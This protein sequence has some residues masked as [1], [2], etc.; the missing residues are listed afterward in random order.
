MA[1]SCCDEDEYGDTRPSSVKTAESNVSGLSAEEKLA[2][3]PG[4][5]Y[6]GLEKVEGMGLVKGSP[7]IICPGP[8]MVVEN[9]D[10]DG[11]P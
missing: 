5:V 9:D 10:M 6:S 3:V 4:M 11:R 7:A 8:P 2:V 1:A